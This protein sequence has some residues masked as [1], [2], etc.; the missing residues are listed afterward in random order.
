M[1]QRIKTDDSLS[2]GEIAQMCEGWTPADLEGLMTTAGHYAVVDGR[3]KIFFEDCLL[4]FE[5]L[6]RGSLG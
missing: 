3:K 2:Y 5:R 4:A 1:G 6:N